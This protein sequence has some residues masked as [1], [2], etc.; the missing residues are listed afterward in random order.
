MISPQ[1]QHLWQTIRDAPKQIDLPLTQKR[2][3]G[4]HAEDV[5]SEPEGVR[6]EP[7]P[8]VDG[9]WAVPDNAR[10]GA[11]I[12]YLFGGGYQI[13]S[14]HSRRKTAGHLAHASSARAVIPNYRLAPEHPFPAAVDDAT[15]AYIWLLKQGAH[16]SQTVVAGD[17][18]GG[19]L[20]VATLLR[21][22]DDG[23]P[24]PA[25]G[26]AISPW[27]DMTCS[28]ESFK[29]N[30]SADITVT[31]DGLLSMAQSYLHAADPRDPEASPL[32]GDVQ[33]LPPL[34]ILVGGDEVLLDDAVGLTRNA[35]LARGD[36]L[37]YIGSGMQHVFP[38]Y[39]GAM[40]EADTA[41]AMI[42]DW[43][44]RHTQPPA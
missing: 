30:A 33:D 21:L 37:L 17:S 32:F 7:A 4:E 29:A 31:R 5:T 38:I 11:A 15:E 44:R 24:T 13:S 18:S 26:V 23:E 28:G 25:G 43:I 27:A 40:P 8:E 3:M 2:A 1:A 10:S 42:G 19:G 41:I 35:G 14:P 6:Y 34:F 12:L 9:I 22:R 39:A 20:T 16:A 36:V